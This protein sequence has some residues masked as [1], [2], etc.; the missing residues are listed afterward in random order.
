M[1]DR[2]HPENIVWIEPSHRGVI[3]PESARVPRRMWR[4]IR[5]ERKFRV[6]FN[7]PDPLIIAA[8]AAHTS[9]RPETWINNTI[10]SSY[11]YLFHQGYC[12]TVSVYDSE[13]Q[14][15]GGLYGLAA[16]S[17][18]FGESMVSFHPRASQI[19]LVA[20]LVRMKRAGFTLLDCQFTTSHLEN[21]GC[22]T[23]TQEDFLE[24]LHQALKLHGDEPSLFM[25]NYH[26]DELEEA[27]IAKSLG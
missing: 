1:A 24:L 22:L 11:T 15:V 16:G 18:F 27:A 9:S 10:I 13:N 6:V 4:Y 25:H 20:L 26:E 17:T 19:A 12:H 7:H 21:F 5:T 3:T 8:C 14:L 23:L 2:N